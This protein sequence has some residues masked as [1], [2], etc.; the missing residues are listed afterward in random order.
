MQSENQAALTLRPRS[1]L[2]L[3]FKYRITLLLMYFIFVKECHIEMVKRI[4]LKFYTHLFLMLGNAFTYD[5]LPEYKQGVMWDSPV[6][7]AS[8][9]PLEPT[10]T[11]PGTGTSQVRLRRGNLAFVILQLKLQNTH[12][13]LHIFICSFCNTL[14]ILWSYGNILIYAEENLDLVT[15][16]LLNFLNTRLYKSKKIFIFRKYKYYFLF[17]PN[18]EIWSVTGLLTMFA[19]KRQ[20][21]KLKLNRDKIRFFFLI[22]CSW[23]SSYLVFKKNIS[24]TYSLSC[25]FIII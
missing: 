13:N 11:C 12:E 18:I 2:V 4:W 7:K 17:L 19:V 10:G 9:Y 8:T 20:E 5:T 24:F 22:L 15:L 6:R 23:L 16:Q 1:Q 14:I 25:Y 21:Q 3:W